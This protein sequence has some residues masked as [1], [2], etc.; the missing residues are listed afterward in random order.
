MKKRLMN[1]RL[2][3]LLLLL[4]LCQDWGKATAGDDPAAVTTQ[5]T[6][7]DLGGVVKSQGGTGLP[8]ATVFIST[9]GPRT[10]TSTFCPSCYADCQKHAKADSLG[11]FKIKSLDPQL[12]FTILVVAPGYEP[13]YVRHVDPARGPVTVELTPRSMEEIKPDQSLRGKVV[14]ASGKPIYGA[15]VEAFGIHKKRDLGT[16]WGNLP[17]VDPLAVTDEQGEFL[18]TAKDPFESLD[19]KVSAR[20][21]ANRTFCDLACKDGAHS[22]ELT[23]GATIKGRV[24]WQGKPL[25]GVSVGISSVNRQ[26]REDAGH[27]EIATD[28]EG[29]FAFVNLPPRTEF[30]LYGL[31]EYLKPYGAI[32]P[33]KIQTP[34]DGATVDAGDLLVGPALRLAGRVVLA[35]GQWVPPNTQLLIDREEAWDSTQIVLATNGSFDVAGIP[36]GTLNLSVRVSGYRVSGRNHSLDHLNPYRLTGRL[37][38]DTTNLVFLLEKG[39]DLQPDYNSSTPQSDWPQN[40]PLCGAEGGE[41]H[42][43]EWLVSGQI[44]DRATR[45][46]LARFQVTPGNANQSFFEENASWDPS[47]TA[48]C[49]NGNFT[50][51]LDKKFGRPVLKFEAEGYLPKKFSIL[52]KDHASL[53]FLLDK[54]KGPSGKVLLPGGAPAAEVKVALVCAGQQVFL[55]ANGELEAFQNRDMVAKTGADG[56]FSYR[57]QLDMQS[58]AAASKDG[59]KQV[60]VQELSTNPIIVL[61]PWGRITGVLRRAEQ[62]GTNEPLDLMLTSD[63]SP[64]LQY[65]AMTDETGKFEFDYVPPAPLEINGR[66]MLSAQAWQSEPLKQ[67]TVAP[68]Q[69]LH[70]EVKGERAQ[71]VKANTSWTSPQQPT[72]ARLPGSGPKGVVLLPNDT[73]VSGAEVA[74]LVPG[75]YIA[76]VGP[77]LEAYAA[78]Q[79]GLVVKSGPDGRF[80]L[81]P[82]QGAT[83]VVVVHP[84]GYAHYQV[85]SLAISNRVVLEPWGRITGVLELNH[86]PGTNE[87]LVL[88]Q[89][90]F[91]GDE[92]MLSAN[93]YLCRTDDKGQ[94]LFNFVPPGNRTLARLVQIGSHSW[95]HSELS[96]VTV[97]PGETVQLPIQIEGRTVIGKIRLTEEHPEL[98]WD[99]DHTEASLVT[100]KSDNLVGKLLQKWLSAEQ[101][102]ATPTKRLSFPV[103]L[104]PDGSF[105]AQYVSAGTYDL[106]VM[107][108]NGAGQQWPRQ[109]FGAFHATVVVPPG[110]NQDDDPPLD[111]GTLEGRLLPMPTFPGPGMRSAPRATNTAPPLSQGS[112]R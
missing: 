102:T 69:T 21:F 37:D 52:P 23:E 66:I 18:L 45:E 10:G 1:G 61:E 76:L 89:G 46:P 13:K 57:P 91:N 27:Y 53:K 82:I 88:D 62:P 49:T 17:G 48:E 28:G 90:S 42:S 2:Y 97:K 77:S 108:R 30:S 63:S 68:G 112:L 8:Q 32:P 11:A 38:R 67:I 73:P 33:Q 71:S 109:Y 22:L 110:Q 43:D 70:V 98:T 106:G 59:F 54:G 100:A 25:A 65:E 78:Q 86:H 60:S 107:F 6:R 96:K 95:Q 93:N 12:L 47:R 24:L 80:E 7:P 84:N 111:L 3:L 75:Q 55:R 101:G 92:P 94:F 56:S 103:T 83:A 5:T 51:Y 81:P 99:L 72:F 74:L 104:Q 39:A 19:L 79:E 20:G 29:R 35:D 26:I 44:L 58:V 41:D 85:S 40:R 14:D 34:E 9:A 4:W 31:M 36:P 50:V 105:K 64:R 16:M 87:G 15:I